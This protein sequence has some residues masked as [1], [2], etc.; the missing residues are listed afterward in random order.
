MAQYKWTTTAIRAKAE[1]LLA[2]LT[3]EEKA[4]QMTQYDWGSN[5]INPDTGLSQRDHITE[6][7]AQGKVGAANYA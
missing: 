7:I 3:L 5:P 6:Q 1:K 4:G 2:R